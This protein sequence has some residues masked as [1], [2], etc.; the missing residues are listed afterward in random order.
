[1]PTS[2][3]I[4]DDFLREPDQFRQR[5]LSCDYPDLK[6]NFPGRNSQQRVEIPGISD[7]VSRLVGEHLRPVDPPQSH[8]KFRVT[9]ARDPRRGAVH[10]D[11]SQWSA[12]IY[13]SKPEHCR[14]GTEFFRHK[15]TGLDRAPVTQADAEAAG[16][17]SVDA[18][19]EATTGKDGHRASAWQKVMDVPMRY[20]RL[21]MLRPWLFHTAGPGFGTSIEDGRLIYVMFFTLAR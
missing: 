9:L 12:I 21:I 14:G 4:V 5:A 15:A 16:F 10:V 2:L 17:A 11:V 3:V 13:L 18:A 8:G 7:Y 1:M 20:N 19:V 6:G